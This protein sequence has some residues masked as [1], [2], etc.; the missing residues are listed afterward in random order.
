MTAHPI[1]IVELPPEDAI[2]VQAAMASQAHQ[3]RLHADIEGRIDPENAAR[4]SAEADRLQ[5]IAD[6]FD[7]EAD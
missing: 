6:Y 4:L 1:I 7:P 2:A 3:A 5:R